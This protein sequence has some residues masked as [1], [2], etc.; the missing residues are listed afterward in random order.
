MNN[1]WTAYVEQDGDDLVIP[2]PDDML[3][4]LG[5]KTGDTLIWNI[6]EETGAITLS[7]K[8]TWLQQ[9]WSKIKSWIS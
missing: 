1:K 9:K 3:K 4:E 8:E 6:N 7:R 5:W 2:L